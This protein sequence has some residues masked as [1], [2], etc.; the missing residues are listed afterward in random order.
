MGQRT[1][2]AA[3]CLTALAGL[4]AGIAVWAVR[5]QGRVNRFEQGPEWR[6]FFVEL[7]LCLVG[8]VGAGALAGALVHRLFTARRGGPPGP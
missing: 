5:A 4:G 8:G 6:V 7:P 3:G 2:A 1:Q